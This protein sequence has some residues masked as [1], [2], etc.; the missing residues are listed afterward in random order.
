MQDGSVAP[1]KAFFRNKWVILTLI[2]DVA[3]I[4][5]TA[6]LAIMDANKES[7][8]TFNIVPSNAQIAVNGKSGYSNGS[9]RFLPGVYE[10]TVSY[11]D[12][13]TK[14]FT[15]ELKKHDIATITTYLH[16]DGNFDYY[17]LRENLGDFITL[18]Q[19]AA[20][21][22]NQTTDQ[23]ASAESFI[24]D[25]QKNYELYSSVLPVTYSEYDNN[26]KLI[27]YLSARASYSCDITL[28]LKANIYNTDDKALI[29]AMLADAGFNVEDFE[30]EYKIY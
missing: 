30:I 29:N 22:Y 14:T 21:G 12:L 10:I 11:P 4:I 7:V 13:N 8:I 2:F 17:R 28:C 23:D 3:L 26:G 18:S 6:V 25:F 20:V 19:I 15:T 27:K 16:Q 1:I 24:A 9:Y 5:F